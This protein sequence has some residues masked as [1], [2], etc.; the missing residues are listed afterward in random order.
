MGKEDGSALSDPGHAIS[1]I[2]SIF[3]VK[4]F[5]E[6]GNEGSELG[7]ENS[8]KESS[9]GLQNFGIIDKKIFILIIFTLRVFRFRARMTAG[10]SAK[11]VLLFSP[12]HPFVPLYLYTY[13]GKYEGSHGLPHNIRIA[14]DIMI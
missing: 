12:T 14:I 1:I 2:T 11:E 10:K 9:T 3:K 4:F 5:F 7:D 8:Y 13:G 6:N